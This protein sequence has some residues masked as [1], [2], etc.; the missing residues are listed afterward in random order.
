MKRIITFFGLL[1]IAKIGFACSCYPYEPN[2]YKNISTSTYNC[3]AV[4]DTMDYSYEYGG[5]QG[6]TGFFILIDTIGNFNSNIGDTIVVTGQDGLNCGEML[7]GFSRGDTVF[8]ALSNGF[9]ETFE[10]D[11]FYLEGAC[12]KYFQKI[13]NGKYAGLTISEIKTKIYDVLERKSS[14]C[15]CN[16]YW[17]NYDF[18]NNVSKVASNCLAVFHRYDYSYSYGG[19]NSQTGYFVL[20]DTIGDFNTQIGDTIYVIGEDGINCGEML[21]KFSS[22]DT[23]FLALSDG[24]YENFEKDTFYLKGGTC[25]YYYLKITDGQNSGLSISEIKDKIKS[26]ITGIS[27]IYIEKRL[28]IF[29]NPT[30]DLLTLESENDLI[31]NIKIYDIAGHLIYSTGKVN[32]LKTNIDISDFKTGLYNILIYTDKEQ[33]FRKILK[34]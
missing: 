30:T 32:N 34:E 8:L 23:L 2:F 27:E 33:M 15:F 22:G 18:Y 28:T 11:T 24:Y 21:N 4:F 10:K 20:I 25:G 29:P 31:L 6:Q 13:T 17:D 3:I 1:I 5:L 16:D 26:K 12:G 9:Y 7:N 19:L 14:A